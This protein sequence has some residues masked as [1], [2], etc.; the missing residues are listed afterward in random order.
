MF[1]HHLHFPSPRILHPSCHLARRDSQQQQQPNLRY[2]T[3]S[4]WSPMT[5]IVPPSVPQL[6]SRVRLLDLFLGSFCTR[7]PLFIWPP[8]SPSSTYIPL[9]FTHSTLVRFYLNIH[10]HSFL[11]SVHISPWR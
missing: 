4:S 3:R 8:D 2:L 7:T 10:T 11:R 6:L 5:T 1:I 9:P